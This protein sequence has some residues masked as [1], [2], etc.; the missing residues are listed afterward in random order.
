VLAECLRADYRLGQLGCCSSG[1]QKLMKTDCSPTGCQLAMAGTKLYSR[2]QM[3]LNPSVQA[4]QRLVHTAE[5]LIMLEHYS[6]ARG[7]YNLVVGNRN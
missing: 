2:P 5:I 6:P 3:L 1:L 7:T 4:V